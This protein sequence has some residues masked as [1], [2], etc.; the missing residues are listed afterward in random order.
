MFITEENTEKIG[1]TTLKTG[2]NL[3]VSQVLK[4]GTLTISRRR[5]YIGEKISQEM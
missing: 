2:A 1:I 4:I 3:V 5:R